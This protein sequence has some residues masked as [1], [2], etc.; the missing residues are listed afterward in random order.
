MQ[1][2]RV[3]TLEEIGKKQ[4]TVECDGRTS[5]DYRDTIPESNRIL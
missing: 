3:H 4:L 1:L 2:F 5:L